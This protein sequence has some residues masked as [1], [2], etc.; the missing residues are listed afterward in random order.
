MQKTPKCHIFTLFLFVKCLRKHTSFKKCVTMFLCLLKKS[1]LFL[2]MSYYHLSPWEEKSLFSKLS[3]LKIKNLFSSNNIF[4]LYDSSQARSDQKLMG[5]FLSPFPLASSCSSTGFPLL[6][7][8]VHLLT[9][10]LCFHPPTLPPHSQISLSTR[11][12][13]PVVL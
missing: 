6:W 11:A 9:T 10:A 8:L 1:P 7:L 3:Q 5:T 12:W 4:S 13:L 2:L